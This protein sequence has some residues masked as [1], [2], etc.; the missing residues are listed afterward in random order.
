MATRYR[1]RSSPFTEK[2]TMNKLP[3]RLF[4]AALFG[5]AFTVIELCLGKSWLDAL[6]F[7]TVGLLGGYVA[8]RIANKKFGLPP[9][10]TC[11]EFMR[12]FERAV[13]KN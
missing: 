11:A 4:L 2:A 8:G 12:E 7:G 6:M 10:A 13:P 3:L 5:T 9:K 1:E